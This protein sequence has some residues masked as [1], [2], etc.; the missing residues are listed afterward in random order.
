M[1]QCIMHIVCPIVFW[2]A[3]VQSRAFGLVVGQPVGSYPQGFKPWCSILFFDACILEASVCPVVPL[4]NSTKK[5]SANQHGDWIPATAQG[6][7]EKFFHRK[8]AWGLDPSYR[9]RPQGEVL[10]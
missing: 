9:T 4:K 10:S 6:L 1:M 3:S 5:K 2:I 7:K 8:S